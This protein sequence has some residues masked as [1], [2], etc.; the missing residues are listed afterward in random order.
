[1]SSC[2]PLNMQSTGPMLILRTNGRLWFIQLRLRPINEEG[3]LCHSNCWTEL[4][5]LITT[6]LITKQNSKEKFACKF[7]QNCFA[8]GLSLPNISGSWKPP[9]YSVNLTTFLAIP[10]IEQDGYVQKLTICP[11]FIAGSNSCPSRKNKRNFLNS[12]RFLFNVNIF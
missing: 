1:M 6:G 9:L 4:Y 7:E 10:F 2:V 11:L 8:A 12:E 5:R 3:N